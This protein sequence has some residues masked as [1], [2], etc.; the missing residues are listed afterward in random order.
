MYK[1]N[2]EYIFEKNPMDKL[3]HS[4]EG[5]VKS[6]EDL[7]NESVR[8]SNHK[9]NMLF[10]EN[11]NTTDGEKSLLGKIGEQVAKLINF[12]KELIAYIG[13]TVFGTMNSFKNHKKIV[14]KLVKEHPE[15]MDDIIKGLE[16]KWFDYVDIAEYEHNYVGL[17]KM[18][19]DEKISHQTFMQKT[20]SL[21]TKMAEALKPSATFFKTSKELVTG[22]NGTMEDIVKTKKSLGN[23]QDMLLGIERDKDGNV[24]KQSAILN[25]ASKFTNMLSAHVKKQQNNLKSFGTF[26][27][28]LVNKV[29]SRTNNPKPNNP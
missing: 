2:T 16:N 1:I 9:D 17:V 3:I 24:T 18:L 23:M 13:D 5:Y 19:K 15:L 6:S 11:E 4:I 21:F 28:G 14:D 27:S 7:Y 10:F 22:V 8:L 26:V 29:T 20:N 12:I 25:T